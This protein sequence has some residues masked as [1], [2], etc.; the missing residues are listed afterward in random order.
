MTMPSSTN[1]EDVLTD[2]LYVMPVAFMLG[3]I[4]GRWIERRKCDR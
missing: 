3:V 1:W 4:I 2:L